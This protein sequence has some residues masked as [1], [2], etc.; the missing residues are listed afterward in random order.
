MYSTPLNAGDTML[1]LTQAR[2]AHIDRRLRSEPIIWLSSIRP[3]G[4]PHIVPVWF[5]WDGTT[6]LI[7]SQPEA[8][9]VKNLRHNSRVMLALNTA[10]DGEDVI[11]LE[12]EAQLAAAGTGTTT[13]AAPTFADKYAALFKRIKSDPATMAADYSQAI[14]VTPLRFVCHYEGE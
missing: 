7:F 14:V 13:A 8:Q 2:D 12:G 11:Y 10:D 4:R 9:K 1:D 6:I 5:W 3:D